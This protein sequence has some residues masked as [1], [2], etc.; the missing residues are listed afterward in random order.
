M[1]FRSLLSLIFIHRYARDEEWR[2]KSGYIAAAM[3]LASFLT[4]YIGLALFAGAVIYL[5][6]DSKGDIRLR[7]KK[8]ALISLIFLIPASLWMGRGAILRRTS[9]PPPGLRE[10]LSYEKELV[11]VNPGDPHSGALNLNTFISRVKINSPVI[12]GIASWSY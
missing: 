6:A 4:R 2:V 12:V 9:P 10:F 5:L 8:I 7:L 1:L 11:V 3:I